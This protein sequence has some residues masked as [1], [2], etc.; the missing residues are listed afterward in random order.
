MN[1]GVTDDSNNNI[2]FFILVFTLNLSKLLRNSNGGPYFRFLDQFEMVM[3]I[4]PVIKH[5]L[6][7]LWLNSL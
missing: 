1:I 5:K 7:T 2:N 4:K 6:L 3:K